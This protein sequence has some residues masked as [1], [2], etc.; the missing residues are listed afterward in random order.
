MPRNV[1]HFQPPAPDSVN[2]SAV[3]VHLEPIV[4]PSWSGITWQFWRLFGF[5]TDFSGASGVRFLK[6][7]VF[8][9]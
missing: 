3:V 1:C 8:L 2:G 7:N 5:R 6:V 4:E 9:R